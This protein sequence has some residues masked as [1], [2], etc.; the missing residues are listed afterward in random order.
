MACGMLSYDL[1]GNGTLAQT[2]PY[3]VTCLRNVLMMEDG[4]VKIG[5]F[6]LAKYIIQQPAQIQTEHNDQVKD[7]KQANNTTPANTDTSNYIYEEGEALPIRWMA[8]EVLKIRENKQ[9]RR[10]VGY[11]KAGDVWSF[12]VVCTSPTPQTMQ[13]SIKGRK[14]GAQV[15]NVEM[16]NN[17]IKGGLDGHIL[18]IKLELWE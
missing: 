14:G 12:G 16:R 9:G 10:K 2:R 17:S 1:Q 11:N 15:N 8:P 7:N 3:T 13:N 18:G 4:T 5:D 6:G